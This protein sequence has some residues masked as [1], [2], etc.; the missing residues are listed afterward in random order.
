MKSDQNPFSI[1]DFFPKRNFQLSTELL[2]CL[3]KNLNE[4]EANS[5]IQ[6][7]IPKT[8]T[9]PDQMKFQTI[10]RIYGQHFILLYR[11]VKMAV[12]NF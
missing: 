6:N 8:S 10:L 12:S 5:G 11:L 2:S 7:V 9:V 3:P 4:Y 1:L